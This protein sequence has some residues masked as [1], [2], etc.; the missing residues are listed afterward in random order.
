MRARITVALVL[1]AALTVPA[2][3]DDVHRPLD[4]LLDLYVRDGFVYYGAL[5]ADR[6]RLDRY[7][8]SLNGPQALAQAS[9]TPV[10]Q[11]ALWI[12]AYNA[13]VLKTVIDQYPIRQRTTEYPS[14]SVRQ[15]PGA[16]ERTVHR[17]AGRT[18]T[19]DALEKDVLAPL[20]DARALLALGRGSIGGGRLRSEAYTAAALEAQLNAVAAESLQREEVARVDVTAGTLIVSPMFSWR[21]AAFVASF[22]AQAPA[23][24]ASRSPIERAVLGLLMPHVVPSEAAFLE[25]N[26]FRMTF[27][28]FDWR[29]NDL[30]SRP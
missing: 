25:K 30:G 20:G 18:T 2:Q 23:V 27:G 10:E 16:F 7:L 8:A 19:L 3:V 4:E 26:D 6:A 15:I 21:E 24:F 11:Q 9:G 17:V 13:L 22:A 14:G 29:L 12:N 1:M 5:K 28:A